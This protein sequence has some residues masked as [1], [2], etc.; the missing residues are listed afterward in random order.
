MLKIVLIQVIIIQLQFIHD[1]KVL[2]TMG[3]K[4]KIHKDNK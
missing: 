4:D 2:T 1:E 3:F